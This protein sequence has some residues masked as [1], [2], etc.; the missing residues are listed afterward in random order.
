MSKKEKLDY[1]LEA[2]EGEEE[3]EELTEAKG[4]L[5]QEVIKAIQLAQSK[6]WKLSLTDGEEVITFIDDEDGSFIEVKDGQ[7][8]VSDYPIKDLKSFL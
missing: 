4:Q 2:I 6:G 7:G 3:Q 1:F 8:N 5:S